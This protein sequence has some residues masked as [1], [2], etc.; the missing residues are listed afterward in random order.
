MFCVDLHPMLINCTVSQP[1]NR[2]QCLH[3]KGQ[4][5]IVVFDWLVRQFLMG[6]PL[7]FPAIHPCVGS[8]IRC[9][10]LSGIDG[11]I[12]S[13]NSGSLNRWYRTKNRT[14][15]RAFARKLAMLSEMKS[16]CLP[17][18]SLV[19]MKD[20]RVKVFKKKKKLWTLLFKHN[21]PC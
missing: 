12:P 10:K 1:S 4:N 5:E 11:I 9:S 19:M 17:P 16:S 21:G 13:Q 15:F 18:P 20:T 7:S 6:W 8:S 2:F 3:C 14:K